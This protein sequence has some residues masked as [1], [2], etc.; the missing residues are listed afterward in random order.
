[1]NSKIFVFDID[2]TLIDSKNKIKKSTKEIAKKIIKEGNKIVLASARPSRSIRNVAAELDVPVTSIIS[3]N[4]SIVFY[5][6]EEFFAKAISSKALE[7]IIDISKKYNV[8]INFYTADNWYIEN[9]NSYAKKE[10]KF[11]GLTPEI[12]SNLLNINDK[13]FK[14]LLLAEKEEI[15]LVKN[16][17]S[18]MVDFIKVTISNDNYCEIVSKDASKGIAL[19]KLLFKLSDEIKID[20]IIVFGDGEN[21]LDMMKIAD[22][23]IAMENSNEIVK[24]EANYITLNNNCDA[25]EYAVNKLNLLRGE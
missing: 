1:M 12:V 18:K 15:R 5:K 10:A 4:G 2:G 6:N 23:S 22:I 9:E 3:L 17:L 25:I 20:D 16:E 24:K 7:K 11:T 19:K 14:V 8:N 13:I 21:D